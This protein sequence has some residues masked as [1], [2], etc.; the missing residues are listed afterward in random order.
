LDENKQLPPKYIIRY[1]DEINDGEIE[2]M[3]MNENKV[4]SGS[5]RD[6]VKM[7]VMKNERVTHIDHF[8]DTRLITFENLTEDYNPGDVA[9]IQPENFEDVIQMVLDA[10]NISDDKLDRLFHLEKS[11]SYVLLPPKHILTY[12]T[13]LR[14]CLKKLFDINSIPTRAFFQSLSRISTNEMEKERLKEL[15]DYNSF[16]DFIDYV[17]LPRRSIAEVLRDFPST[18]KE[19]PL[20]RLFDIFPCIRP[21]SFSIA[22]S[23]AVH[24][25]SLQILVARVEYNRKNM[26]TKRIGLCSNFMAKLSE[27]DEVII[28]IQEGTMDFERPG[29]TKVCICTG[30]GIAPF[31][32]LIAESH[33]KQ[34]SDPIV[35]F[36]GCRGKTKDFYFNE[37][38]PN[39]ANCIVQTA[40][41][42]DQD[43]KVYVHHV[44][45]DN[46][47]LLG[48]LIKQNR[49]TLYAFLVAFYVAGSSGQM[50]KDIR[51]A[52]KSIIEASGIAED[53]K[54]FV[55]E[56]ELKRLLQFETWF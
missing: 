33:S 3:E 35:L 22:S 11:D 4:I 27:G 30:T 45:Q 1:L 34:D 14:I 51:A 39:F 18:S 26:R 47:H 32:S 43:K 23:R 28:R 42:R 36:F 44:M 41:S 6:F 8:Q 40:F 49:G 24:P 54:Q 50:P 2:E 46:I 20:E 37:E 25:Q 38:W 12:P 15:G 52:L 9:Q 7:R 5:E 29:L 55:S 53:G 10:L 56:M 21:R 16:D 17:R 19:I 48:R 13:T 31:R